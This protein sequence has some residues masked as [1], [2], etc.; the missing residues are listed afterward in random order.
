MLVQQL[1]RE[2]HAAQPGTSSTSFGVLSRIKEGELNEFL[3][4]TLIQNSPLPGFLG[5]VT[6]APCVS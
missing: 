6:Y 2:G 5:S 3:H 4:L 1:S